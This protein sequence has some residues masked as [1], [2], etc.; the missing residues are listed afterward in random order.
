MLLL[1]NWIVSSAQ[2]SDTICYSRQ[3]LE[4]ISLSLIKGKECKELLDVSL[5]EN[6]KLA[7]ILGLY[8]QKIHLLDAELVMTNQLVQGYKSDNEALKNVIVDKEK[9][10]KKWKRR[11]FIT[12]S[13]SIAIITTI[14]ITK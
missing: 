12:L 13:A 9:E 5:A 8:N 11:T 6:A 4:K 10:T 7:Q 1:V 14:L 3:Y 2:T